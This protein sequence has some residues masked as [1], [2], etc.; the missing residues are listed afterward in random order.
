MFLLAKS[1]SLPPGT[2]E[3]SYLWALEWWWVGGSWE[4]VVSSEALQRDTPV[5]EGQEPRDGGLEVGGKE[6]RVGGGLGVLDGLERDLEL[7]M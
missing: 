5:R 7:M 1:R 3:F 6:G 4:E 2:S